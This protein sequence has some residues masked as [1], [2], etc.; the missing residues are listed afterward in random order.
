MNY[1]LLQ[2]LAEKKFKTKTEF[3]GRIG[4]TKNGYDKMLA[5]ESMRVST[6]ELAAAELGVTE[7]TLISGKIEDLDSI[8]SN[9]PHLDYGRKDEATPSIEELWR[10][11]KALEKDNKPKTKTTPKPPKK[12]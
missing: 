5:N 2:L 1:K 10:R 4:L 7:Q 11:V 3:A 8:L 6:L 9:E 12:G